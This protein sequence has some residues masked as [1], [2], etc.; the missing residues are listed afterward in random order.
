MYI[1]SLIA[2]SYDMMLNVPCGQR[3]ELRMQLQETKIARH[4]ALSV[5]A[6]IRSDPME[7][8]T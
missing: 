2:L 6:A 3:A 1:L 5:S 8:G 4:C 7:Y